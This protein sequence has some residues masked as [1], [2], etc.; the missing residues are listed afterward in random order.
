MSNRRILLAQMNIVD[1][2]EHIT[3]PANIDNASRLLDVTT[4]QTRRSASVC[5]HA[6]TLLRCV[7]ITSKYD[8]S[9]LQ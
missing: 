8:G 3:T 2:I 1:V 5:F 6:A 9:S 7:S 4:L